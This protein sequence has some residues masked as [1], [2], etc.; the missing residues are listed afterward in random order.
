MTVLVHMILLDR[1]GIAIVTLKNS[2]F[3]ASL[4]YAKAGP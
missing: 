4:W 3:N 2:W 1:R